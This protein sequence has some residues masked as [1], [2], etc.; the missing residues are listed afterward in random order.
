LIKI[1]EK[2][3]KYEKTLKNMK[4]ETKLLSVFLISLFFVSLFVGIVAAQDP[5]NPMTQVKDY[6][7]DLMGGTDGSFYKFIET[8]LSPN[9]LFTIL[10]FLIVFAIIDNISVFQRKKWVGV[11]VSL[12]VAILA[13]GFI[14]QDWISPILNQYTAIGVAITFLIPFVLIFYFLKEIAPHNSLI[15]KTVWVVFTVVIFFN[16][17]INWDKAASSF[18]RFLYGIIIILS[19]VMIFSTNAI[20][21]ML[22]KEQLGTAIDKYK[23]V[24]DLIA[25]GKQADARAALYSIGTQLPAGEKQKFEEQISKMRPSKTAT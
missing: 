2:I 20:F 19:F 6:L 16:I 11:V 17:I 1:K 7:A 4:K 15:Q 5:E 13:A 14:D 3:Y 12:V 22:F 25:A 10:I 21:K 24:Q 23:Q 9:I 18:T 8:L